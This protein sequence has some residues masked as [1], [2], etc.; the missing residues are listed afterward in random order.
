MYFKVIPTEG[1]EN[2]SHTGNKSSSALVT[3]TDPAPLTLL[4]FPFRSYSFHKLL[5]PCWNRYLW[6]VMCFMCLFGCGC[7][8]KWGDANGEAPN[9]T[10]IQKSHLL[11][12]LLPG[13]CLCLPHPS[14]FT[15]RSPGDMEGTVPQRVTWLGSF[16]SGRERGCVPGSLGKAE[17]FHLTFAPCFPQ[18]FPS[19]YGSMELP[20]SLWSLQPHQ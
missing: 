14:P 15:P 17:E 4:L 2:P 19:S 18:L 10:L 13:C 11:R 8:W 20:S 12:D 6:L 16:L 9:G 1:E 3:I 7:T 5:H